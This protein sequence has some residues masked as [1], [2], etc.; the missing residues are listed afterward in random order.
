MSIPFSE[1]LVVPNSWDPCLKKHHLSHQEFQ[2]ASVQC[3]EN[4]LNR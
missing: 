4:T 1:G 2:I 3:L